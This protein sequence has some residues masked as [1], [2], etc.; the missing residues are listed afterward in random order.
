MIAEFGIGNQTTVD[1]TMPVRVMGYDYTVYKR[2]L[3]EYNN[4]TPF[5]ELCTHV[6][7]S[8]NYI[9]LCIKVH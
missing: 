1:P 5:S 3:D 2:Q 6:N 7:Q 4:K 8:Y 9:S